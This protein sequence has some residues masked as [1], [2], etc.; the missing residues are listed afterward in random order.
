MDDNDFAH[1]EKSVII[2]GDDELSFVLK[3]ADGSEKVLKEGLKVEDR[4]VVDATFMSA[5]ALDSFLRDQV[6]YAKENNL[7]FSA[8]LKATMMKVSDPIL[9]GHVVRAY[10]HD[11]FDK[12]GDELIEAGLNGENGLGHILATRSRRPSTRRRKTAPHWRT[13]IPTRASPPCT[14]LRMSSWTLRCL[15]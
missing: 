9:F 2:D 7:L 4:E 3:A 15:P 5:K 10:F 1:N 12:Y 6:A 8:H 14:C 13:S 11:V